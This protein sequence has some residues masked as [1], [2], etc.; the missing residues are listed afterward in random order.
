MGLNGWGGLPE[1]SQRRVVSMLMSSS[2][3][4]SEPR[5]TATRH[6]LAVAVSS[7]DKP[8]NSQPGVIITDRYNQST[9]AVVTKTS[10]LNNHYRQ[11]SEETIENQEKIT[12]LMSR[13]ASPSHTR[14]QTSNNYGNNNNNNNNSFRTRPGG[15]GGGGVPSSSGGGG[16]GGRM[17]SGRVSS[18][19][20]VGPQPPSTTNQ[21]GVS[22]GGGGFPNIRNLGIL[23]GWTVKLKLNEGPPNTT[24]TTT[25]VNDRSVEG[26]IWCYDPI[27]GV[28]ILESPGNS[29]GKHNY[30]MVKVNQIKDLQ[31]LSDP[32]VIPST[33]TTANNNTTTTTSTNNNN[34]NLTSNGLVSKILE[35]VN[36]I[37]VDSIKMRQSLALENLDLQRARIG[38]GVSRWAQEIFDALGKTLPV[39]WHQTS[40]IILDEV[41]LPGPYYRSIDVKANQTNQA[42][43]SRVKQVLDGEWSR[44]LRTEEGKQMELE[45][46]NSVAPSSSSAP[47]AVPTSTTAS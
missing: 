37:H 13:T 9:L 11:Q 32:P 33:T 10:Y 21:T 34:S 30:R 19:A 27:P 25:G 43:M 29:K 47:T 44:L 4:S 46:R 36:H 35:P 31:I 12:S 18:P 42:S 40:I 26:S 23:L 17:N 39:R 14:R 5:F 22:G 38:L 15:G 1:I 7:Q 6:H 28:V 20:L 16:G 3:R 41:L 8:Y 24:T 45:A 2:I